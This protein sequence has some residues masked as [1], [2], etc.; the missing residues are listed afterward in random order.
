MR[1]G[2]R[3]KVVLMTAML[4]FWALPRKEAKKEIEGSRRA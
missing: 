4:M 2:R 1:A 3:N